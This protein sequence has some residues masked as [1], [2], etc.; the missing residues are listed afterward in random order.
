[1]TVAIILWLFQQTRKRRQQPL[2]ILLF[3]D[4]SMRNELELREKGS[5]VLLL[6]CAADHWVLDIPPFTLSVTLRVKT[7]STDKPVCNDLHLNPAANCAFSAQKY[8]SSFRLSDILGT[9]PQE[10]FRWAVRQLVCRGCWPST[11]V[12]GYSHITGTILRV[13]EILISKILLPKLEAN[14]KKNEYK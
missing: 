12:K 6:F 2:R 10:P 8:K 4:N 13:F 9:K 3:I 14:H 11:P 7:K 5:I 1:M